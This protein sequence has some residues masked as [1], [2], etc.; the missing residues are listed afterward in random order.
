MATQGAAS[1]DYNLLAAKPA[2]WRIDI[3]PDEDFRTILAYV[4]PVHIGF[5]QP[6]Q[7]RNL[8][9]PTQRQHL[10]GI[11]RAACSKT[12]SSSTGKLNA[13][14]NKSLDW[15]EGAKRRRKSLG[16]D[17]A[18]PQLA[19]E[20]HVTALT[21]RAT[22][23]EIPE[24]SAPALLIEEACKEFLDET[25][26]QLAPKTLKQYETAIAYFQE[27][28]KKRRLDEVDRRTL[29][30][31]RR[32]LGE[33]KKR[34]QRTIWTKMMVVRQMLKAYGRAPFAPGRL[35]ALRGTRRRLA[36]LRGTRPS[37]LRSQGI[38]ALLCRLRARGFPALPVLPRIRVPGQRGAISHLAEPQ[39][40]RAARARDGKT[41]CGVLSKTWEERE[42]LLPTHLAENLKAL[43]SSA[44]RDCP[45]VFPSQ[46]GCMVFHFLER[47]KRIAWRAGSTAACAGTEIMIAARALVQEPVPA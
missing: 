13:T 9:F 46:T 22:A 10:L 30:E 20:R 27:S 39:P 17:A 38:E 45:W 12:W 25:R 2:D 23:I 24:E 43:K 7:Q 35:A 28:C 33:E 6:G 14:P 36:A 3:P 29:L 44:N 37:G 5:F 11:V 32:Y 8:E 4:A 1:P 21:A 16:K 26:L 19:F 34:S 41:L 31:F 42:V 40:R 18:G 15:R 47:L